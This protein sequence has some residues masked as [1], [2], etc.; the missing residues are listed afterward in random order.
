MEDQGI[1]Q[2]FEGI[3]DEYG[4]NFVLMALDPELVRMVNADKR[5]TPEGVGVL[6][7]DSTPSAVK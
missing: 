3:H 1:E 2:E 5:L 4:I 6:Q 7:L